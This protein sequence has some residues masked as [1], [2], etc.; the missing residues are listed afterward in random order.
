[1]EIAFRLDTYDMFGFNNYY[2]SYSKAFKN[3]FLLINRFL[4]VLYII[5]IFSL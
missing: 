5:L 4:L 3:I 2:N 1:M